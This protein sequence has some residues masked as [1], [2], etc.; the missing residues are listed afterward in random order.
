MPTKI[1]KDTFYLYGCF[2]SLECA[3]AY[4]FKNYDNPWELYSLLH[5]YYGCQE[6]IKIA[7][8]NKILNIFGGATNI[9]KFRSISATTNI[10][11]DIVLPPFLSIIPVQKEVKLNNRTNYIPID[12][13]KLD[14]ANE[15]LRSK[16][17]APVSKNSLEAC[18]KLVY[19]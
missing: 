16:Q 19:T 5:L 14:K 18:M 11:H 13:E 8:S 1:V 9:N 10:T 15:A 4:I 2:C 7:P 3:A 17:K 12:K 6:K